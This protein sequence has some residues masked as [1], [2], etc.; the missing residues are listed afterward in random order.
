MKRDTTFTYLEEKLAQLLL[1]PYTFSLSA[2]ITFKIENTLTPYVASLTEGMP[3]KC[4][5]PAFDYGAVG[6]FFG[7]EKREEKRGR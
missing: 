7:E 3:K 4:K 5:L 2:L 1:C 6:K